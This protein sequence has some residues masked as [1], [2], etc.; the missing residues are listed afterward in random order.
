MDVTKEILQLRYAKFSDEALLA[1][2]AAGSGPYSPLAWQVIQDL[3][4]ARGLTERAPTPPVNPQ[5]LPASPPASVEA[6]EPASRPAVSPYLLVSRLQKQRWPVDAELPMTARH[7]LSRA[8]LIFGIVGSVLVIL[9]VVN[10]GLAAAFNHDVLKLGAVSAV[11]IGFAASSN[12]PPSPWH[13]WFAM[14]Y[15]GALPPLALSQLATASTAPGPLIALEVVVGLLWLLYFA[16]RRTAY[17]LR[18]GLKLRWWRGRG[19]T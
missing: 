1:A 18:P 9:A 6:V 3:V 7:A 15:S 13:W 17:G 16:R 4:V 12:R 14:L 10:R 2:K 11:S 19:T 5:A 8:A